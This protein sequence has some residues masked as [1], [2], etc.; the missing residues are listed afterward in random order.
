MSWETNRRTKDV[1]KAE[2]TLCPECGDSM[3]AVDQCKENGAS[4]TWY[5]CTRDDCDG[6]WLEKEILARFKSA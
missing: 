1:Q 6:Q 5:D 3:V 4:F 2:H